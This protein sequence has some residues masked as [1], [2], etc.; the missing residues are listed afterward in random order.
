MKKLLCTVL[1]LLAVLL[2]LTAQAG[3][4]PTTE[5]EWN[6]T[7]RYR[8]TRSTTLYKGTVNERESSM[9]PITYTFTAIGTLPANSYVTVVSSEEDGKREVLYWSGG[10]KHGWID[11]DSYVRD[12]VTIR[13]TNGLTYAIPRKAYGDEEAVRHILSEFYSAEDIESFIAGMRGGSASSGK[14]SSSGTAKKKPAAQRE[15]LPVITLTAEGSEPQAVELVQPGLYRSLIRREGGD[16]TVA[17]AA[18]SWPREG[19]AQPLAVIHAPR[20]GLATLWARDNGTNALRKLKAGSVVLVLS[21]G[22]RYARVLGEGTVGYVLKDAL[23]FFDPVAEAEAGEIA[24]KTVM[25]LEPAARGRR[26]AYLA[27]GTEVPVLARENGWCLVEHQG[28]TGWIEEAS[29]TDG[30][31]PA[32]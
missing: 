20:T 16:E 3:Y 25:R 21:E 6:K 7:C 14:P 23:R 11:E 9:E 13:A 10:M 26:L 19:T 18:L 28:L 30:A 15:A 17:T 32:P 22:E 5:T 24:A 8:T 12:T 4:P 27:R 31:D 1:L 29:L 2:P